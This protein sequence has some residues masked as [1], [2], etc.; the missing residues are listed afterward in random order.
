MRKRAVSLATFLVAFLAL[1]G[2]DGAGL[3]RAPA[4]AEAPPEGADALA[5][6]N[7]AS[8]AAYRGAKEEALSHF[9]P[10]VLLEGD[11]LVLKNGGQRTVVSITPDTYTALK[12][13]SHVPLAVHALLGGKGDGPLSEGRLADL[14]RYRD[15]VAG[16]GKG[17]GGH[18]LG[19]AQVARQKEILDDSVKFLGLV[20]DQKK[21]SDDDLADY[22]RRM[23]PRLDANVTEAA[24][25]E[26]D[27]LHRQMT[28]WKTKWTDE[29]WNRLRV[30][31]MG[32]RLPRDD[33]LA[34]QYFDRLLGEKGEGGRVVYSEAIWDEDK[35]L[36]LM[37][38]LAVD[39][40]IGA[41]FFGD[42]ERMHRDLLG[43]AARKYLDELFKQAGR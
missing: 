23:R 7:I 26:I 5:A 32:S 37:A 3:R 19:D 35:A 41:A 14:R 10:V 12:A 39:G 1:L 33:S 25:A 18:G 2:G 30:I 29:E 9:G 27:A 4:H 6:L 13:V 11:D 15:L 42:P 21:V 36:E 28:A 24:R 40:R 38:T 16:A 31:V 20:L 17:L 22:L 34:V 43:D 8:R